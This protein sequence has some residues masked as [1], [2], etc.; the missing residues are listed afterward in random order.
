MAMAFI[1]VVFF[2]ESMIGNPGHLCKLYLMLRIVLLAVRRGAGLEIGIA[3]SFNQPVL[4][5]RAFD[6]IIFVH[7]IESEV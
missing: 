1:E 4:S 6:R 7:D 5:T 2:R 3:V